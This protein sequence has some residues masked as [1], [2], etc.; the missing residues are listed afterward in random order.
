MW[1]LWVL[2]LDTFLN[3]LGRTGSAFLSSCLFA[4]FWKTS[5]DAAEILPHPRPLP[6]GL[7]WV[8]RVGHSTQMPPSPG[9]ALCLQVGTLVCWLQQLRIRW[10]TIFVFVCAVR[11]FGVWTLYLAY[12]WFPD[13]SAGKAV[14]A[15]DNLLLQ[16]HSSLV[17]QTF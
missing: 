14:S 12:V 8:P 5:W 6:R 15:Y 9:A 13:C 10:E 11:C 17:K 16:N 7:L 2:P 3:A 4:S 1:E